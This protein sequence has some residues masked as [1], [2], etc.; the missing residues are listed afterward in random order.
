MSVSTRPTKL[1]AQIVVVGGGP[2]AAGCASLLTSAGA[3]V[4]LVAKRTNQI[5]RPAELIAPQT[6]GLLGAMG[7][8]MEQAT[9]LGRSI[10]GGVSSWGSE[11]PKSW[12]NIVDLDG[13]GMSVDRSRFDQWMT[14]AAV[15]RGVYALEDVELFQTERDNRQWKIRVVAHGSETHIAADWIVDATGRRASFSRTQC[16]RP[17]RTD[18][19]LALARST[20]TS[21]GGRSHLLIE[22]VIQGWWYALPAPN[23]TVSAV[24][25]TSPRQLKRTCQSIH[26]FWH[27]AF[28]ASPLL[29]DQIGQECQW[30]PMCA[31]PAAPGSLDVLYGSGW[32]AIG[33]AAAHYDPLEGHGVTR[34]LESAKHAA[35][36]LFSH[37]PH[38]AL[39]T[40]AEKIRGTFKEHLHKRRL[41][42][43]E[44]A[45]RFRGKHYTATA[46]LMERSDV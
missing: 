36:V 6:L 30:S 38:L 45:E 15:A 26:G 34:A 40:Y 3:R 8:D 27:S 32:L 44:A 22:A 28:A 19:L 2:A 39:E 46:Q 10:Y 41:I 12:S 9:K 21:I 17:K 5:G 4:I 35:E 14:D 33:D 23:G 11:T 29:L 13:P 16:A 37:S 1:K 20:L 31:L 18:N 25:V 24:I 42:Y 43:A 7:F